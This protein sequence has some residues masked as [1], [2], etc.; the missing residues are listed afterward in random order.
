MCKLCSVLGR[1]KLIARKGIPLADWIDCELDE[2][3]LPILDRIQKNIS[4]HLGNSV[5]SFKLSEAADKLFNRDYTGKKQIFVPEIFLT[6]SPAFIFKEKEELEKILSH[7]QNDLSQKEKGK[8]R[9]RL[10]TMEGTVSI[11][12]ANAIW[13]F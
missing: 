1:S 13:G 4:Y 10:A 2:N 6:K 8:W 3:H 12:G 9:C 11:L 5:Q 7:P